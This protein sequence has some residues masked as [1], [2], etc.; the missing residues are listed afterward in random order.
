MA[1]L[2]SPCEVQLRSA[3][4]DEEKKPID[5]LPFQPGEISIGEPLHLPLKTG[6]TTAKESAPR[7]LT[8]PE[9]DP[10]NAATIRNDLASGSGWLGITVDDSLIIGRLVIVEIAEKSPAL[11]AGI[12]LQDVLLAIDGTTL[13]SSDQLA[14]A[15]A[16]IVPGKPV[17]VSVG[18]KDRIDEVIITAI[19]RPQEA[20]ARDWQAVSQVQTATSSNAARA[21]TSLPAP[22][23]LESVAPASDTPKA[24][25]LGRTA[26]GVR[27]I[28]VDL[29][30]QARFH[31]SQPAGALVIGVVQN[32][33][34]SK[35]GVPPGSVIVAIDSQPVRSPKELTQL[36]ANGRIDTPVTLQYVMPGGEARE[37]KVSLQSLEV[38][39]E[40]VLVGEAFSQPTAEGGAV[41]RIAQKQRLGEVGAAAEEISP[42]PPAQSLAEE[43]QVLRKQID[44]LERKLQ[45][46][47]TDLQR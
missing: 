43:V 41:G 14:A 12:T 13:S 6:A 25:L 18:R 44:F 16:A 19:A 36:V 11:A 31:L 20:I 30:A 33:P 5:A 40:R 24:T 22:A 8:V 45:R 17:K 42:Q 2:G 1:V 32:L 3:T 37:A 23:L 28:P 26:L 47:E 39:L 4:A 34:A 46:I 7:R 35:A 27:T 21:T 38:P 9:K 29:N 10:G 15:L